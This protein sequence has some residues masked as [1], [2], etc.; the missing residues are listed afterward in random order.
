MDFPIFTGFFA[1]NGFSVKIKKQISLSQNWEFYAYFI[2]V[3]RAQWQD[4]PKIAEA[5]NHSLRQKPH[6]LYFCWF[7]SEG[8]GGHKIL[9]FYIQ[10]DLFQEKIFF[11]D[12]KIVYTNSD[13]H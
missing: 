6:Y 2:K 1:K 10:Y 11:T 3:N 7:F 4:A 5:Q 13:C 12:Q 9:D 8:G